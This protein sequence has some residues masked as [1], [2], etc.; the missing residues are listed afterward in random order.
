[1]EGDPG[2]SGYYLESGKIEIW[3]NR[4][5]KRVSLAVLTDGE[6]VGELS[7]VDLAPRSASAVAVEDCVVVEFDHRQ[8]ANRIKDSASSKR[9]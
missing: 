4:G 3:I 7:A 1:M 6:F 2:G 8:I 9:P 5:N